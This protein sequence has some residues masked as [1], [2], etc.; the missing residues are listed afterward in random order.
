LFL[1][2]NFQQWG[3]SE[4]ARQNG[5]A[6]TCSEVTKEMYCDWG[7]VRG[8]VA[9]GLID[10]WNTPTGLR[11]SEKSIARFKKEYVSLA[12]IA[13]EMGRISRTLLRHCTAKHIPI[14]VV[15]HPYTETKH[16]FVRLKDRDAVLS[17]RPVRLW[18]NSKSQPEDGQ[19]EHS[20][21]RRGSPPLNL[22]IV[23]HKSPTRRPFD[24]EFKL[25]TTSDVVTR[26]LGIGSELIPLASAQH[27][28][29]RKF[30]GRAA[31]A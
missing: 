7:C 10:G 18:E 30:S 19:R 29:R 3:R 27:V 31:D 13:R 2:P 21:R 9:S 6:R 24:P 16:A 25:E 12:S 1:G 28:D 22:R 20:H 11:I 23:P 8:L 5:N 4:R 17:F 26:V 14:L 15:K